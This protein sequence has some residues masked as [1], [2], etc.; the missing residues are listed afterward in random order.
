MLYCTRCQVLSTDGDR[1]PLCGGKKLRPARADDPVLLLTTGEGES[2]QIAAAF[3][4]AGIPHMERPLDTGSASSII[5]GQSRCSQTRVF[6]P[7]GEI[8]TA[9]DVLT[10]IGFLHDGTDGTAPA[11][12]PE[13]KDGP[14]K[15][16]GRGKRLAVCILSVLL[17]A[18]VVTLVVFLAD[19]IAGRFKS[20]FH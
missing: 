19:G 14:E 9:R 3:D 17:F 16:M 20:L 11:E 5:L 1:C 15:T 7:F 12:P 6:V 4:D 10:G 13:R 8:G 18:V 2:R